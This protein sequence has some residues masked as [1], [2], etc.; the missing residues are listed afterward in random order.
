MSGGASVQPRVSGA[1][2]IAS[3]RALVSVIALGALVGFAIFAL[4]TSG[5]YEFIYFQF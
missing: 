3:Q 2:V 5:P 4:F 1:A